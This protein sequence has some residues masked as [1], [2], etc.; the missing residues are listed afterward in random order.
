MDNW[1]YQD[2]NYAIS[3]GIIVI[4]RHI[5]VWH[6]H[7]GHDIFRLMVGQLTKHPYSIYEEYKKNNIPL[8][9]EEGTITTMHEFM[10]SYLMRMGG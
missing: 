7:L 4:L 6:I 2:P 1:H 3:H 10:C 8:I 9:T 5:I